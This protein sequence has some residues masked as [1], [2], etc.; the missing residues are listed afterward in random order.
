MAKDLGL[1]PTTVVG[2]YPQPDSLIDR[3]ALE[4]VPR[5]RLPN[6]W[7]VPAEQLTAA[8][9]EATVAAI[10]DQEQAGVDIVTDGEI[11][12]ESYSNH[13]S[14][15]LAGIDEQ[16]GIV[17]ITND[18]R[19]FGVEVPNFSSEVARLAP[20]EVGNARFLEAH[21]DRVTKMTLPGPFT[22]AQQAVTSF[23]PD[24]RELALALADAVRAEMI[25]LFA[26]GI[27]IVQL[28]E[29][30]MQ[31]F[32]DDAR[33]YGVEVLN[34]ALDGVDGTVALHICFGYAATV[35]AKPSRY[36]FLA[37]FED[38]PLDHISIE[39]AQPHLDLSSLAG[40]LPTKR[41]AVGVVDL[42]DPEV[43]SPEMVAERVTALLDVIPAERL[44]LAPDCGM[45]F[46]PRD[47]ALGKLTA[48]AEGTE[49]VRNRLTAN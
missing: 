37:E 25:D 26:A 2:S 34:R 1:L 45:K 30:W 19:S 18:G 38:T 5:L 24:K 14:N 27:D 47:R 36:D 16:P 35:N 33:A 40:I 49:L 13:F 32:P 17:T 43:E 41:L 7:K 4:K 31:R 21:T 6:V 12:R 8:Q 20:V 15:A 3:S 11:R 28:D 46:L 39:G 42:S 23:Y 22:M 29:P 9:D 48:L 10:R 44:M